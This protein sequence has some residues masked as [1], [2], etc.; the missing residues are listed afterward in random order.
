MKIVPVI[1]I[2][3]LLALP[4][5]AQSVDEIIDKAEQGDR[6]AQKNLGILYETTLGNLPKAAIWYKRAAFNGLVRA[7]E[8]LAN[9]YQHGRGVP[10]SL[11][12][13]YAWYTAA[14]ILC[15]GDGLSR[16]FIRVSMLT[17]EDKEIGGEVAISILFMMEGKDPSCE[18]Y[19]EDSKHD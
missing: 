5:A 1:V 13:A 10:E 9:A 17:D 16:D 2:A 14:S 11:M 19:F 15:E 3:L 18:E 7:Q 8:L 12:L 4:A 6:A